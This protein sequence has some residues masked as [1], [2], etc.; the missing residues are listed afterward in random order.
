AG[1]RAWMEA[2]EVWAVLGAYGIHGVEQR[3]CRTAEEVDAAAR[4]L[5]GEFALKAG[6]EGLVHKT[7][8]GAVRLGVGADEAGGA[9]REMASRLAEL[10]HAPTSFTLQRMAPAGLEMIV[11]A[12][13][14]RQFGPVLACGAGGT[15][16][17]LLKDV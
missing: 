17:E 16:V 3:V 11:G 8:A 5:G 13:H 10:G 6:A 9:A 1:G 14:D 15:M 4:A 7:E 2:D 12:V